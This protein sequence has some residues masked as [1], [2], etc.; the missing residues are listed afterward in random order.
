MILQPYIENAIWHGIKPK[1]EGGH[2][3]V[4]IFQED[5]ILTCEIKDNGVGR[6]KSK[7][8]RDSSILKHKSKD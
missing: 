4:N 3:Q 1:P 2:V 8:M 6:E 7:T 5:K